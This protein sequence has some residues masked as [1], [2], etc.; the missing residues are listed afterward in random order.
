MELEEQ[1]GTAEPEESPEAKRELFPSR[2][3]PGTV[4][5]P[6]PQSPTDDMEGGDAAAIGESGQDVKQQ[7]LCSCE[8][9]LK[10]YGGACQ[11]LQ[12]MLSN[13]TAG[14]GFLKYLANTFKEADDVLYSHDANLPVVSENEMASTLPLCVHIAA[15]G[16]TE[17]ASLKPPAGPD[18]GLKLVQQILA[19]GFQSASQPLIVIQQ[20]LDV[21]PVYA[22]QAPWVEGS[23][24]AAGYLKPFNL[25]YVKGHARSTSL[26]LLLHRSMVHGVDLQAALPDVHSSILKIY[27][28]CYT[29]S[30]RLDEALQNCKLS[31]RG[32]LRRP[33][34]TIQMVMMIKKLNTVGGLADAATFIR[35]WN[36]MTSR[37]FQVLGRRAM[38]LKLLFECT[39]TER[40]DGE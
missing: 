40:G 29:R 38:A 37:C 23:V 11:Y 2:S 1:G 26:L 30:S 18:L 21:C 24:N 10:R 34:N 25:A 6:T 14:E 32:S 15:L 3:P 9:S 16:F 39:P 13:Q 20:E 22:L 35:R 17:A 5:A 4:A 36:S 19:E 7:L 31:A 28:H 27:V 12:H 8:A 33:N